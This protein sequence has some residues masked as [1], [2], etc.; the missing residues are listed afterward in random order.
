VEKKLKENL[1]QGFLEELEATRQAEKLV[2]PLEMRVVG[3]L[4]TEAARLKRE[5]LSDEEIL[6]RLSEEFG[7]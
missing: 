6:R 2:R 1:P 5:G 7:R 3:R 4:R